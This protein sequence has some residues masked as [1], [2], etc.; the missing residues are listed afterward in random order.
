VTDAPIAAQ[1]HEP[2]DVHRDF[3]P[4]VAFDCEV[5]EVLT[6]LRN[7]GLAEILDLRSRIDLRSPAC[8]QSAAPPDAENVRQRN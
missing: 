8:L 6:Q 7:F 2:L 4:Q 1:I 3:A 5:S